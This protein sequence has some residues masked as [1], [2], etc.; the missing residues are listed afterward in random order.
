DMETLTS[1]Y[2]QHYHMAAPSALMPSVR[3][4]L[5]AL[6]DTSAVQQPDHL[7]TRLHRI[8]SKVAI[9]AGW[10]SFRMHDR[11]Q[12]AQDWAQAEALATNAGD[13]NLR[14]FALT[15]RSNLYSATWNPG[16]STN[17]TLALTLL[18]AAH[19]AID[20]QTPPILRAW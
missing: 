13:Q 2:A 9:L 14:A 16:Q 4:H 17:T 20:E 10:L 3:G 12:A 1:D 6:M 8:A 11:T 15:S 5:A 18:D 19:A 7:A